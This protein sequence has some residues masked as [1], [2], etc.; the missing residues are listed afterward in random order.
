M[1]AGYLGAGSLERKVLPTLTHSVAHTGMVFTLYILWKAKRTVSC[2]GPTIS[3]VGCKPQQAD[4]KERT[5][6]WRTQEDP[7]WKN[8][9]KALG[10]CPQ[11][12]SKLI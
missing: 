3:E 5:A 9:Q 8:D 12:T 6:D 2:P 11:S 7:T 4:S 1:A 10:N